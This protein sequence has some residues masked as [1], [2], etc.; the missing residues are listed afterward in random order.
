MTPRMP[1][2]AAQPS[3]SPALTRLAAAALAGAAA[4]AIGVPGALAAAPDRAGE[5]PVGSTPFTLIGADLSAT[6]IHV[7]G[8][9][10]DQLRYLDASATERTVST[11]TIVALAPPG[12]TPTPG[13]SIMPSES[14]PTRRGWSGVLELTDGQ[15]LVGRPITDADAAGADHVRWNHPRLGPL[16]VPIDRIA[17]LFTGLGSGEPPEVESDGDDLLILVNGDHIRGL[18]ETIGATV[19]IATGPIT[20]D[21]GAGGTTDVPLDRVREVIL[22]NPPDAP[23]GTIL[24]FDDGTVVAADAIDPRSRGT[25]PSLAIRPQSDLG[26]REGLWR[27]DDLEAVNFDPARLRA[28][29]SV[30]IARHDRGPGSE[31]RRIDAP[32]VLSN[33]GA[34]GGSASPLWADDIELPGPMLAEWELPGGAI[35]LA[36]W[37]EL[38]VEN[39]A[40]G[41]CV[42]VISDISG[43]G[44]ELWRTRLSADNPIARFDIELSSTDLRIT[45]DAGEH[46][47][48][49]DRVILRRPLIA[50]GE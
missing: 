22:T 32:V 28:L 44:R 43:G 31:R 19:S 2:P 6:P 3:R 23:T 9:S 42:L 34:G 33:A 20:A 40:W 7:L 35:R 17:S 48:I 36:G 50:V 49:Q 15:R 47:P 29:A 12:W 14:S 8:W 30:E 10:G 41:D 38:P 4:A 21:A 13:V 45:L 37:A 5:Q 46:G 27:L 18:V 26:S 16:L 1:S 39:W 11:S 25:V 24:W